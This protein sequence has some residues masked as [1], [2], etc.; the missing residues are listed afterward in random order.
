MS[1]LK[2]LFRFRVQLDLQLNSGSCLGQICF[3]F[4]FP[5]SIILKMGSTRAE[6]ARAKAMWVINLRRNRDTINE[7]N[8][9]ENEL[10]ARGQLHE[11]FTYI[12]TFHSEFY[13]KFI[14]RPVI[15]GT[16][17]CRRL[18]MHEK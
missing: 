7:R 18:L 10:S 3:H 15:S 5:L 14:Q 13:I 1:R 4:S 2:E 9:E 11:M 6:R 17:I 16:C 8:S 12:V